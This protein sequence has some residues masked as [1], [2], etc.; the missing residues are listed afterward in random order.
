[1]STSYV[2]VAKLIQ[3]LAVVGEDGKPTADFLRTINGNTEN[4]ERAFNSLAGFVENI[5]TALENAGIAVLTA[6]QY[7]AQTNLANS[8]TDP[9]IIL[10][11]SNDGS[12]CSI[13]IAAHERVYGD[14]T[15]VAVSGDTVDG[16]V[17]STTYYVYYSDPARAGGAVTYE[18]STNYLDAGQTGNV[19]SCG[20]IRTQALGATDPTVG[21]GPRPPGVGGYLTDEV[22]P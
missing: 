6:Q 3:N 4:L 1:M 21:G 10:S 16:L 19:H 9:G 5:E 17:P 2:R 15:R 22:E 11:G 12:S 18:V 14:G 8:Y 20:S 7:A 13:T